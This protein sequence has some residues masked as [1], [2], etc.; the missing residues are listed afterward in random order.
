[1]AVKLNF[2][3]A[4]S[5]FVCEEFEIFFASLQMKKNTEDDRYSYDPIKGHKRPPKPR[6]HHTLGNLY[7][8]YMIIFELEP[9][10]IIV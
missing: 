6:F 3:F 8:H 9:N 10:Y 5:L 2:F 4:F 7:P 1:M